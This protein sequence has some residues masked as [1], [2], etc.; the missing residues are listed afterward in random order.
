[1]NPVLYDLRGLKCPFP[2]IK[3]RKKLAAMA[4]GTL[5]RVDTTDPLAVID[6]PHFCNEDGHELVET[7]K[8]ENGHRFV[9]RKR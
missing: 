4:S 1:M 7:E 2:V 9:I 5:I 6:M 8:T 3:T